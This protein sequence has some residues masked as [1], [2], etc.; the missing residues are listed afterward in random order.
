MFIRKCFTC[1]VALSFTS[2]LMAAEDTNSTIEES[3]LRIVPL[4][5]SSPLMGA[6]LGAAVSYLYDTGDGDSSKSQMRVGGQ[7]SNTESYNIFVNNN[8]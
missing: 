7:Y 6:G 2:L 3:A 4:I 5:T 1:I 8:A